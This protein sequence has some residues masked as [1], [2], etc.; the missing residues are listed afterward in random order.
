MEVE[1]LS[2][3]IEWLPTYFTWPKLLILGVVIA[4][5]LDRWIQRRKRMRAREEYERI[6]PPER[7]YRG[8]DE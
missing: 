2:D 7:K 6:Y 3:F 4:F 1:T 5:A 8:D